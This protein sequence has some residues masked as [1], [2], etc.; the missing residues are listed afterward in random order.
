MLT[1]RPRS[2]S[3]RSS[4][5]HVSRRFHPFFSSPQTFHN[6]SLVTV[7]WGH[8]LILFWDQR[9]GAIRWEFSLLATKSVNLSVLLSLL[10]FLLVRWRKSPPPTSYQR[11]VS[12]YLLRWNSFFL[13][14]G[15]WSSV[16][17]LI[18]LSRVN[19]SPGNVLKC[20]IWLDGSGV[21]VESLHF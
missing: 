14:R 6:P 16:S 12:L 5:S 2:V 8:C 20:R 15:H 18:R 1:A 11:A 17:V 10:S 21:L 9:W 7:S 3:L 19:E 4:L 13:C